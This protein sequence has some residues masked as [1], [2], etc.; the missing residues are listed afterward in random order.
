MSRVLV[1]DDE[2]DL[3]ITYERLLRRQGYDVITATTRAAGL[4]AVR[5][6]GNGRRLDLVISDLRLPDG[7]GLDVV[8]AARGAAN[9]PPVFV[10]SGFPS[11]ETRRAAA[12]A[13]ATAFFS[14]PFTA[15]SL[16]A[17]V[18]STV[19]AAASPPGR[20]TT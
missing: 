4:A 1:V 14:K 10:I 8:R 5:A 12:A 15:A 11:D 7:D 20:D 13:G 3:L 19:P 17:A 9:P 16:L 2:G 6:S 18:R